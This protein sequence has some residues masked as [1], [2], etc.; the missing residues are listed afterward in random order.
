MRLGGVEWSSDGAP[1]K[2]PSGALSSALLDAVA[3]LTYFF[4]P[5]V[6]QFNGLPADTQWERVVRT[7]RRQ[8]IHPHNWVTGAE[9]VGRTKELGEYSP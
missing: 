6:Q 8:E 9:I 7:V 4:D 3:A 1:T 2:R 5:Q